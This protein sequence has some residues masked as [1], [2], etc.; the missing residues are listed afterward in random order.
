MPEILRIPEQSPELL[1]ERLKLKE[2]YDIWANALEQ[3]GVLTLFKE[4]GNENVGIV[5]IKGARRDIPS[6]DAIKREVMKEK[7]AQELMLAV[8]YG[9][10]QLELVPITMDCGLLINHTRDEILRAFQDPKRGLFSP[11]DHTTPRAPLDVDTDNPLFVADEFSRDD[12]SVIF[13]PERFDK[14]NPGGY[15][16]SQLIHVLT[17]DDYPFAGWEVLLTEPGE[18]PGEGAAQPR[19]PK[20]K[21]RIPWEANKRFQE[22]LELLKNEH[23]AQRM[24]G[25]TREAELT[26]LI[27]RIQTKNEVIDDFSGIGK[28]NALIGNYRPSSDSVPYGYWSRDSRQAYVDWNFPG[29]RYSAFGARPAVRIVKILKFVA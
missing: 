25:S 14:N 6:Y 22:Y 7:N 2:Q 23:L 16:K 26:R 10:T 8:E 13:Y 17:A 27:T 1:V 19:G 15:T 11:G 3:A 18:I 20:G 12:D 29:Y 28:A 5:D 4:L 21:E 9:F 24:I